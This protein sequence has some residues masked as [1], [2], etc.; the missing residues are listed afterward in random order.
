VDAFVFVM[1]MT[2]ATIGLFLF[3]D[4]VRF[5][6]GTHRIRG[7]VV[8]I[9]QAFIPRRDA[10]EEGCQ[11][12]SDGFYPVVEYQ[13]EGEAVRFTAIEKA[14][15]GR[16]HVGDKLSLKV[17]KSRRKR[18]RHCRSMS[19]LTALMTVLAGFL[20]FFAFASGHHLSILKIV[21]AS[22]VLAFGFAM[23]II[24][25]REHDEQGN[26][27]SI[28]HNRAYPQLCLF[29]P[30]AYDKWQSNTRDRRQL[31]R[32]RGVRAAAGFCFTSA[33]MML[34]AALLPMLSISL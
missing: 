31:Q 20:V 22:F 19:V 33:S 3:R 16:F 9:Q 4:Y 17:S 12:V 34:G 24:Y 32:I 7:K 2:L 23:F 30:T 25:L 27:T 5:L 14:A 21:C 26:D 15:S 28:D 6:S 29:E 18:H 13:S 1:G 11:F 8:T 10:Q